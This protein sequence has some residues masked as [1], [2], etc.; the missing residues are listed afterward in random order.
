V[1]FAVLV[2]NP[3]CFDKNQHNF[4]QIQVIWSK[5]DDFG[6]T[7]PKVRGNHPKDRLFWEKKKAAFC[8]TAI[9]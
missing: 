5:K 2:E 7:S 4:S 1:F 8:H 6:N 3:L 9:A